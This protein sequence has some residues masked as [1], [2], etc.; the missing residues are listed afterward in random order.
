MPRTWFLSAIAP[1]WM[2]FFFAL[3]SGL[4]NVLFDDESCNIEG[5]EIKP[6]SPSKVEPGGDTQDQVKTSI[7]RYKL[8]PIVSNSIHYGCSIWAIG[9]IRVISSRENKSISWSKTSLQTESPTSMASCVLI[10]W[11]GGWFN[12]RSS[13]KFV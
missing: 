2:L 11:G 12:Q 7:L 13:P 5:S 1:C 8:H 3:V 10:G 9:C 6:L 4:P